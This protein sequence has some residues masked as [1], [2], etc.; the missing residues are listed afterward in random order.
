MLPYQPH[1]KVT[2]KDYK[3]GTVAMLYTRQSAI[4]LVEYLQSVGVDP[5]HNADEFINADEYFPTVTGVKRKHVTPSLVNHI[6]YYSERM[7]HVKARGMFSQLNT[8]SRFMY[9]GGIL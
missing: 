6:G 2:G 3:Y 5:I 8:D 4:Q 9:D 7:A 1:F